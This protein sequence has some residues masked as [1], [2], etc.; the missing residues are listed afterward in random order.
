MLG[1]KGSIRE[2]DIKEIDTLE[3]ILS[4]LYAIGPHASC[5]AVS[6]SLWPHGMC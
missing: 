2:G 4:V 1:V 6:K 5:S 3:N